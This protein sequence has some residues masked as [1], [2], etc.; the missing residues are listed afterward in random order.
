LFLSKANSILEN[1]K[2][3]SFKYI[4]K[5]HYAAKDVKHRFFSLWQG[6]DERGWGKEKKIP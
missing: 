6:V 5:F 2:K 3:Y 4:K 1:N